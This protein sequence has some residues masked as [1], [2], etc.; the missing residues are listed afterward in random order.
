MKNG[1]KRTSDVQKNETLSQKWQ[2]PGLLEI[3]SLF[4]NSNQIH[5][6]DEIEMEPR[7]FPR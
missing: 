5:F 6:I 3:L 7:R 2:R 1:W 4:R